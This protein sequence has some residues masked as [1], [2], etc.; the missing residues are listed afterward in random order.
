MNGIGPK[1]CKVYFFQSITVMCTFL[2]NNLNTFI[3]CIFVFEPF[4]H[5]LVHLCQLFVTF[6]RLRGFF[7]MFLRLFKG[8]FL[9]ILLHFLWLGGFFLMFSHILV[10]L[11]SLFF[12]F[13]MFGQHLVWHFLTFGATFLYLKSS[14]S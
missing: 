10:C 13:L 4:S 5:L 7:L 14:F 1:R 8:L 9:H 12:G 2:F 6:L 3:I 11:C